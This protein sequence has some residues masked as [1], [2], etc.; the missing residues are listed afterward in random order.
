MKFLKFMVFATI[1]MVG[2]L[3]WKQSRLE[4]VVVEYGLVR[5]SDGVDEVV[6]RTRK[7]QQGAV[8]R[9]QVEVPDGGWVECADDCR[10]ALGN[11]VFNAGRYAPGV[12]VPL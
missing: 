12:E 3:M 9:W 8:T 7:L 5:A 10:E 6:G 11:A 4:T 2:Y 1:V